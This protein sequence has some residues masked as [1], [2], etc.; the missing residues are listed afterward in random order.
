MSEG[1]MSRRGN[2]LHQSNDTHVL[3]LCYLFSLSL[4]VLSKL[5]TA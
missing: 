2:V 1:E 3:S 5:S 4:F